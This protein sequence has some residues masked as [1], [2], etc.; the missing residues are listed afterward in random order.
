M[1][2]LMILMLVFLVSLVMAAPA[3][4]HVHLGNPSDECSGGKA[5]LGTNNPAGND[6]QGTPQ[7]FGSPAPAKC[8]NNR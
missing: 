1:K 6:P 7:A 5:P 4:A 3:M 2:K 8:Q